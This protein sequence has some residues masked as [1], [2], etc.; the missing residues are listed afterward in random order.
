MKRGSKEQK[1][2]TRKDDCEVIHSLGEKALKG[3][4]F[5]KRREKNQ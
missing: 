1:N 4:S 2:N 3:V 5:S